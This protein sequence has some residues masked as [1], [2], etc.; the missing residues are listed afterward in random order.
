MSELHF[1]LIV[2]DVAAKVVIACVA[3]L[4]AYKM[5]KDDS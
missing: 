5:T 3:V 4:V 2:I 1:L